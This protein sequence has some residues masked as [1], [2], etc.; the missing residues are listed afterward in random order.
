VSRCVSWK[1]REHRRAG[2][3]PEDHEIREKTA[4]SELISARTKNPKEKKKKK[5]RD[6]TPALVV[7]PGT[8]RTKI[9]S[10]AYTCKV[11]EKKKKKKKKKSGMNEDLCQKTIQCT[12]IHPAKR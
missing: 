7:P 2:N 1:N 5:K 8:K 4:H 9:K 12:A 6:N 10:D 11:E 3:Q